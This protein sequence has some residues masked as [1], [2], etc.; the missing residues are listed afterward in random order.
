MPC[1]KQD[2]ECELERLLVEW[3]K[4]GLPHLLGINLD[5]I[6]IDHDD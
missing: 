6:W 3:G 1:I 4:S 2:G 5:Q